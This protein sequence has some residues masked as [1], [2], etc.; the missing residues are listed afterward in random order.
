MKKILLILFILLLPV[1]SEAAYTIFLKNGSVISGVKF[2]EE[3]GEDINLYFSAGSVVVS[4]K[5][6]LKIEG[7]ESPEPEKEINRQ[8]PAEIQEKHQPSGD[9]GSPQ[10]EQTDDREEKMKNTQAEIDSLTEQI[11]T[12]EKEEQ[13]LVSEINERNKQFGGRDR[14]YPIQLKQFEKEL[15]PLKQALGDVQQ[16][17]EQLIQKR[18]ALESQ[19]KSEQ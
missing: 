8:Q 1:Y 12:E 7:D 2:Y 19:F 3:A 15:E 10:R 18:S 5:D 6:V 11:R 16:K 17:K 9:T 4:K 13:R 14:Y